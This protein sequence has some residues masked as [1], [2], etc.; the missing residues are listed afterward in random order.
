VRPLTRDA[1]G[2]FRGSAVDRADGSIHFS[3][4]TQCA[5]MA[6]KPVASMSGPG[7]SGRPKWK[8]LFPP[9]LRAAVALA[10]VRAG[11]ANRREWAASGAALPRTVGQP[12]AACRC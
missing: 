3:T 12:I 4:A 6:A 8:G 7:R 11:H 5:G 2:E 1:G 10:A 9:S